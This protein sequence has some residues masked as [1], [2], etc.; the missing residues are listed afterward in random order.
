MKCDTS[1]ATTQTRYYSHHAEL[2]TVLHLDQSHRTAMFRTRKTRSNRN[3]RH[4]RRIRFSN[5]V[6]TATPSE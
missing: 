4:L 2:T 5:A 1:N 6:G 3:R